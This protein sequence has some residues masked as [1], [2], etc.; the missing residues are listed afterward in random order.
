MLIIWTLGVWV[1]YWLL[2]AQFSHYLGQLSIGMSFIPRIWEL[3]H[4]QPHGVGGSANS[5]HEG[6]RLVKCLLHESPSLLQP[7]SQWGVSGYGCQLFYLIPRVTK[8]SC[9]VF[10]LS[11]PKLCTQVDQ[12]HLIRHELSHIGGPMRM[13]P[14]APGCSCFTFC[15]TRGLTAKWGPWSHNVH[16]HHHLPPCGQRCGVLQGHG[17]HAVMPICI[18]LVLPSIPAH[19]APALSRHYPCSLSR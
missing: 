3:S 13:F 12:R 16:H 7:L 2:H 9:Q 11:L 18:A 5:F 14:W 10:F 6:A 17:V 1:K 8:A 4:F 19:R 15:W